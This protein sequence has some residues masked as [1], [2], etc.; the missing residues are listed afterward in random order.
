ML[1]HTLTDERNTHQ[2]ELRRLGNSKASEVGRDT[3]DYL[4]SEMWKEVEGRLKKNYEEARKEAEFY[5]D[6]YFAAEKKYQRR[7]VE[8]GK[9][10]Q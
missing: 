2:E 3:I 7:L 4:S 6:K 1:R 5:K 8:D 9:E 10:D